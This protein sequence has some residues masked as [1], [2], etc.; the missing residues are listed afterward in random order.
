[1]LKKHIFLIPILMFL[2]LFPFLS[3]QAETVSGSG[4]TFTLDSDKKEYG[5]EDKITQTL[6]LQN[7][8]GWPV[9]KVLLEIKVPDGYSLEAGQEAYISAEQ[10][11]NRDTLEKDFVL[12]PH[13]APVTGDKSDPLLWTALSLLAGFLAVYCIIRYKK[14]KKATI[15][16][17]CLALLTGSLGSIPITEAEEN[18][19]NRSFSLSSIV[20][21]GGKDILLSAKASYTL[22]DA[23]DNLSDGVIDRGEIEV[24]LEQGVIDVTYGD[25]VRYL[26]IDGPFTTHKI[27]SAHEAAELLNACYP[28]LGD[29]DAREDDIEVQTGTVETI[30]GYQK[31]YR[32]SPVV[33]SL[34]VCGSQVVLITSDDGMV[35]GMSNSYN[36]EIKRLD[37]NP[38]ISQEEAEKAAL[39]AMLK[40][41]NLYPNENTI[42]QVYDE[43]KK[44][45]WLSTRLEIQSGDE[46]FDTA[47]V[48]SV[49]INL[50]YR[51]VNY[52]IY[53]NGD[54][55]GS[56]YFC[57]S[58]EQS[59]QD[60]LLG[61]EYRGKLFAGWVQIDEKGRIRLR[62]DLYGTTIEAYRTKYYDSLNLAVVWDGDKLRSDYARLPGNLIEVSGEMGLSETDF[63]PYANIQEVHR[64]YKD[65]LNWP[66]YNGKRATIKV[67]TEF[68]DFADGTYDG[69][70]WQG[71]KKQFII[72]NSGSVGSCLDVLGHEFTHA[73]LDAK[74]SL[75]GKGEPGALNEALADIMGILIEK[76][77]GRSDGW[78]IGE[79]SGHVVRDIS[80]EYR[81]GGFE[82]HYQNRF[83]L[84]KDEKYDYERND[85][86]HVH[87]NSII[88][89]H[90]VF[91]MMTDPRTKKLEADDW[92]KIFFNSFSALT[93]K[94]TFLGARAEIISSARALGHSEEVIDAIENGFDIVGIS[95]SKTYRIVLRWGE[96]PTDLD[97]HLIGPGFHVSYMNMKYDIDG[98]RAV[99]LD[100]DD[101]DSYGPEIITIRIL[102]PG[103]YIYYV[104]D[105][106]NGNDVNSTEL[107]KSCAYV[108]VY[109]NN[110][111]S[112]IFTADVDQ[113]TRGTYWAVMKID[114]DASGKLTFTKLNKYNDP[115]NP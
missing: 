49:R 4:I 29:I 27:R 28:L 69:A 57:S 2:C 98:K 65:T 96:T 43:M 25:D 97:S 15:L 87:Y 77:I 111:R 8:S 72:G 32:Y 62:T 109:E 30:Y 14:G 79:D 22:M 24:L 48:Y 71:G 83:T 88:F 35:T 16:L 61:K 38:S 42:K 7:H 1:M 50:P 10:L 81:D 11:L 80:S 52:C 58:D 12:V 64:Y 3:V 46:Y 100:H 92:A 34:P 67:S 18:D 85:N 115:S 60:K 5:I 82:I 31:Y 66:S 75:D 105:Y 91:L 113:N 55:A 33:N 78:T 112:N 93:S 9:F 54:S 84:S 47:T 107:A 108:E 95:Q 104:H 90:G 37:T 20:R 26:F 101:T 45:G 86:G 21:V 74:C 19:G 44:Q 110:N 51:E 106:S 39:V 53:S 40:G 23:G 76:S 63:A 36:E 94:A 102:T 41:D 59:L 89:S 13:Q 68:A 99:E 70:A 103:T 73:V 114:I 17:L 56:V 6:K